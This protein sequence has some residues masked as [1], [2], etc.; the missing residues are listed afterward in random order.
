[1][2]KFVSLA[3]LLSFPLISFAALDSTRQLIRS[4]GGII[5]DLTI[6]AAGVA[7]LVFFWGLVKFILSASDPKG[8]AEGK[9]FM[10]WGVIAL[11]VM[12][13]VWGL[14]GFIQGELGLPRTTPGGVPSAPNSDSIFN[15]FDNSS[16]CGE[17]PGQ[18]PCR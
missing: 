15:P 1:M 13:S 16:P 6:L 17:A 2:K 7:L 9:S 3:A 11:F 12:V 8:K 5:R 4:V 10:V 14:V 18:T